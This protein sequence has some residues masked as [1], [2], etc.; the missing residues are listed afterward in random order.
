VAARASSGEVR[1]IG[2]RWRGRK[3]RFP[4][5]TGLRPTPD[6][7]RETL[8][9][10]LAPDLAGST[11]LD[12]FAG[13]GALGLEA[14]SRG[15]AKVTLVDRDKRVCAALRSHSRLIGVNGGLQIICEN[16]LTYLDQP[17]EPVD[18]VF[19]D[20]P[21]NTDL[22]TP[23]VRRLIGR[24][25]LKPEAWVYVE[26]ARGADWTAPTDWTLYRSQKAGEVYGALFKI[27]AS[28]V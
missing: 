22:Y 4:S 24:D 21:Y 14:L 1:I 19:V 27:G 15:A 12:L 13:S 7:V 8:F 16:C 17:G 23:V 28:S 2:G 3:L 18:V 6:R 20:P 25:W 11:C 10:W 5:V 26:M 9:N